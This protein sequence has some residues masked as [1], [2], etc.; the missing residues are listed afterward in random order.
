MW[1]YLP[2]QAWWAFNVVKTKAMPALQPQS[3]LNKMQIYFTDGDE[4]LYGPL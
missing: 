4:K 1:A 3:S 2:S